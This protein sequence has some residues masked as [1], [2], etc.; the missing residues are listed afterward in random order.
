MQVI[1]CWSVLVWGVDR[2]I[3]KFY[4]T[5]EVEVHR[6]L[7]ANKHDRAEKKTLVIFY[8]LAEVEEH[9]TSKLR[10]SA[11]AKLTPLER[12]ALGF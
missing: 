4:I 3:H 6:H 1:E 10:E 9:K 8:T 2:H 11:L 5:S 12:K 7:V